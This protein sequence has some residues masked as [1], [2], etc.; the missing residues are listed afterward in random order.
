MNEILNR[1][2]HGEV[3]LLQRRFRLARAQTVK[4]KT[5]ASKKRG[6]GAPPSN[7]DTTTSASNSA[8]NE[9]SLIGADDSVSPESGVVGTDAVDTNNDCG[10]SA[11]GSQGGGVGADGEVGERMSLGDVGGSARAGMDRE[12]FFRVFPAVQVHER[13]D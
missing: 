7:S 2:R 3:N 6:L 4:N 10:E 8:N 13:V 12:A 1:W 5:I 11:T 9:A